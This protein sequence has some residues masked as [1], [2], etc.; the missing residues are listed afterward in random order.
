MT[1]GAAPT[2]SGAPGRTPTAGSGAP[3]SVATLPVVRTLLDE[4][5]AKNYAGGVLGVRAVPSW[6]GPEQFDHADRT[7]RVVPCVSA[8]AVREALLDRSPDRWL[9]ILTDRD[10]A[11]L[12][13]GILAHFVWQRLR[14]PDPW[15]A[16]R[17]RFAAAGVDPALAAGERHRDI[18]AGLLAATPPG[19]RWPPA[20]GGVLTRDH[21]LG[22]VA[23]HHLRVG[24]AG[25]EIDATTVLTWT[26][27]PDT[28][29]HIAALRALTG[30]ALTDAVLGWLVERAGAAAGPLLTLTLAGQAGDAVPLGLVVGILNRAVN[31]SGAAG[32][33][34][35]ARDA[36]IRL[37]PRL[38]GSPPGGHALSAWAAEAETVTAS[39]LAASSGRPLV[40][41]L[42]VRADAVLGEVHA[43]TLAARSG[44]LPAGL[45]ARLTRLAAAL[46]TAV[47]T[48]AG[49]RAAAGRT[50][51]GVNLAAG[52]AAAVAPAA[53]AAVE[54]AW[55]AVADHRL[56]DGDHRVAVFRAGVWLIRWLAVAASPTEPA[57]SDNPNL[58]TLLA[59]HRDHDAWV[60]AAVNTAA[61]GVGAADLGAAL[62]TVLAAV[63]RRRAAHDR[64]F[65]AA[66]TAH[67]GDD[68]PR[69]SDP[70]P[71][72]ARAPTHPGGVAAASIRHRG[73][74]HLEDLLPGVVLPLA[75][76]TPVLVLVLDGMSVAV[77]IDVVA[78]ATARASLGWV[79]A[80]LAG[81]QRRLAAL[82][83]LPTLT[84]ISRA[85][86]LC[87][88]LRR[89]DQ[90]VEHVGLTDLARSHHVDGATL[91]H[92][93]PLEESPLGMALASDVAAALD[94]VEGHPLVVCV[95]NDIDDALDRSDP[96]GTAWGLAT[97]R[98]LRPLLERARV[99][100]RVVVLTADHGTSSN[101]AT[102]PTSRIRRSPADVPGRPPPPPT[103]A[104][105]TA[106]CWSPG[107][108]CSPTA[109]APCWPSTK[110][111][112]T[113]R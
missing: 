58:A 111:C 5:R 112:V 107:G 36:L 51:A 2:G 84:E 4:A 34:Q 72:A 68:P 77:A 27:S 25:A 11:D 29:G 28:S 65:A 57:A 87:G 76:R 102:A 73:V 44:L 75:T 96:G 100:G 35:T 55:A 20:P 31:G 63:G 42:L 83:P 3:R 46:R 39:L 60:D 30:D 98:R 62:G 47:T 24:E 53:L 105:A 78:D 16:V 19:G 56:A 52:S 10:D 91:F 21:A 108:G 33:A 6:E 54:E 26:A 8:L 70:I 48:S 93:G 45:T 86:L 61:A 106:R 88:D 13:A 66:L 69:D 90:R 94:D 113:G 18:A 89:G 79:E 81:E 43:D 12:G 64:A 74:L 49:R 22:S 82:A 103:A 99:T 32:P 85:S 9:V 40:D 1:A 15:E 97:I 80:V 7:V 71:A 23:R 101:G 95:L 110:G 37:E 17:S 104:P 50:A 41:R 14:T 59:Y 38:G 109:D 92:K 67:T